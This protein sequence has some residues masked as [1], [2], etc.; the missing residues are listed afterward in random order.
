MVNM[1]EHAFRREGGLPAILAATDDDLL[2]IR[3]F[4]VK[5]LAD[6]RAVW[7]VP[8][9]PVTSV[10]KVAEGFWLQRHDVLSLVGG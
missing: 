6:F 5:A 3:N 8:A 4:G 1:L 2:E 7:P 10:P 9:A